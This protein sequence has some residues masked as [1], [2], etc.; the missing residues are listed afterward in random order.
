MPEDLENS[1][2]ENAAAPKKASGDGV[3]VEQH[4]LK[5]QIE[6]DKYLASKEAVKSGR[7]G[8][9]FSKLVPPGG[10]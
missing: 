4:P 10:A 7:R 1:I 6:A 3:S 2:A 8:L 9:R 5:E